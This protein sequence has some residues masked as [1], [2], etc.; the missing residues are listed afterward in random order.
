MTTVAEHGKKTVKKEAL[1]GTLSG[2]RQS[3][4]SVLILT[5]FT[6]NYSLQI[7]FLRAKSRP[8]LGCV[9]RPA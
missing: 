3:R 9:D 4:V 8:S 2:V 6:L 7:C 1:T 5:F